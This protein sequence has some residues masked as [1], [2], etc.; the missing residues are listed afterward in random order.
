MKRIPD[1]QK[2]LTVNFKIDP[3]LFRRL[4]EFCDRRMASRDRQGTE[5]Q[6][7][8]CLSSAG[9]IKFKN[10]GAKTKGCDYQRVS[11]RSTIGAKH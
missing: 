1:G 10:D 7:P 9:L 2:K 5:H 8:I 11:E 6:P 3:D 4:Q